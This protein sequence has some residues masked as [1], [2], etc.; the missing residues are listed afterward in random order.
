MGLNGSK[1][2]KKN[3]RIFKGL[4]TGPKSD[5]NQPRSE[6]NKNQTGPVNRT[7]PL[8][9]NPPP[10]PRVFSFLLLPDLLPL[11]SPK[12]DPE[13][14]GPRTFAILIH[15]ISPCLA[16]LSTTSSFP[17]LQHTPFPN[18]PPTHGFPKTPKPPSH[19]HPFA[20]LH[21]H[22]PRTPPLPHLH[23]HRLPPS[24]TSEIEGS[25]FEGSGI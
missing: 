3:G 8:K 19:L 13:T 15:A 1:G 18:H 7:G 6:Q 23:R 10:L 5:K 22:H 17:L 2:K 14:L 9:I 21:S 12:P 25:R 24:N 4:R 11:L 20:G 16:S